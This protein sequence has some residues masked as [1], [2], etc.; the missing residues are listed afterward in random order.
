MG[1]HPNTLTYLPN[2]RDPSCVFV[3]QMPQHGWP[4]CPSPIRAQVNDLIEG[5]RQLLGENLIGVYLHGSLAA[6]CH[7][8]D[9]SDVD[10]LVVTEHALTLAT[11]HALG[12]FSLAHDNRPRRLELSVLTQDQL[13]P[14]RYPTPYDFHNWDHLVADLV[15]GRWQHWNDTELTDP[16]LAAHIT[17]L[18][19][20]GLCLFGRPI[21]ETFPSVPPEHYRDS[22]LS[23]FDWGL[24]RLADNPTY[25][26]LN[27]CRIAAFIRDGQVLSKVEGGE[28]G[29]EELPEGL[30]GVVAQA[31]AIY[32]G[33]SGDQPFAEN[34]LAAFV[35]YLTPIVKS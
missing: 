20:R 6:G 21:S 5:F 3:D 34:D 24:A 14:W 22:I 17:V 2:F 10:L 32:R 28:W 18:H 31:L 30:H 9:R 33:E 13:H 1:T 4:D 8:P 27:A 12:E 23:D 35:A 7:N 25:F 29:L 16:D 19:Q 15:D 26:I 11:K